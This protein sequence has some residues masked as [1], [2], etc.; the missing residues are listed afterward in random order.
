MAARDCITL[1]SMQPQSQALGVNMLPDSVSEKLHRELRPANIAEFEKE[2]LQAKQKGYRVPEI[3]FGARVHVQE[4]AEAALQKLGVSSKSLFFYVHSQYRFFPRGAGEEL[5]ELT[6][7]VDIANSGYWEEEFPA[8]SKRF[9][10]LS[11]IEGEGS[12][13][14]E[15]STGHVFD[16]LW[17]EMEELVSGHL[18]PKWQSYECFL[19][20]YYG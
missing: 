6:A 10:Q 18:K 13:F 12:Y 2:M 17:G 5:L 20:W 3:D 16:V 9:L 19:V 8:F 1:R 4:Q 15:I 11:S 7:I 14:I